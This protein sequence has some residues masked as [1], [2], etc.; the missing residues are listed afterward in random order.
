VFVPLSTSSST[1]LQQY[2]FNPGLPSDIQHFLNCG[3]D[4]VLLIPLDMNAF[5]QAMRDIDILSL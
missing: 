5:N 3:A 2:Y 4:R 1:Q